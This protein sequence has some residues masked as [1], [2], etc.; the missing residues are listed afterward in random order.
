[1]DRGYASAR[2]K[3]GLAFAKYIPLRP[4]FPPFF[5]LATKSKPRA[6]C[7]TKVPIVFPSLPPPPLL[8]HFCSSFLFFVFSRS[9]VPFFSPFLPF[10]PHSNICLED[11]LDPRT[12]SWNNS[13][14]RL[15]RGLQPLRLWI[16]PGSILTPL[17]Q[18]PIYLDPRGYE[19]VDSSRWRGGFEGWEIRSYYLWLINLKRSLFDDTPSLVSG[20]IIFDDPY[21][22]P[23]IPNY[24]KYV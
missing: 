23:I 3:L 9:F 4:L 1:M 16:H 13:D 6:S 19:E 17:V 18:K 8:F 2:M 12:K 5:P 15:M 22:F 7:S 21:R 24:Y 11:S 10:F 20:W 14:Y